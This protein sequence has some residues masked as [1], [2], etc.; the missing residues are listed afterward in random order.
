VDVE[1]SVKPG[2]SVAIV[3]S[4][5]STDSPTGVVSTYTSNVPQAESNKE[6]TKSIKNNFF[7]LILV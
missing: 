4:A 5:G 3:A 2:S 1:F 7:I 6:D